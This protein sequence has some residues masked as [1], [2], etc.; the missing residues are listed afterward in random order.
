METKIDDDDRRT[1]RKLLVVIG[2][3]DRNYNMG[4]DTVDDA[5]AINTNGRRNEKRN[6][7]HAHRPPPKL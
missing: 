4:L 3:G 5:A 7:S 6:C 1:N 2:G